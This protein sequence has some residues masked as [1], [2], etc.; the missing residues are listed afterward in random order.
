MKRKNLIY[1]LNT[2]KIW[3]NKLINIKNQNLKNDYLKNINLPD[4][5]DRAAQE[6][7]FNI[8]LININRNYKVIKIIERTIKKIKYKKFGYCENC[9]IEI[10]IKRLKANPIAKFCIKCIK[11]M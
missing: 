10:N 6:E 8:K 11:K 9:L 4:L 5:M 3:H 2:L 7:D 1:F